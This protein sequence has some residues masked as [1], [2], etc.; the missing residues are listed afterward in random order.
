M[1][2][3]CVLVLLAILLAGIAVAEPLVVNLETDTVEALESARDAIEARLAEMQA[4]ESVSGMYREL[5]QNEQMYIGQELTVSGWILNIVEHLLYTEIELATAPD[6]AEVFYLTHRITAGRLGFAEG[7]FVKCIGNF[8]GM[9]EPKTGEGKP[10]PHLEAFSISHAEAIMSFGGGT[11]KAK[12]EQRADAPPTTEDFTVSGS[13][14]Y[15][16]THNVALVIRNNT[17]DTV[18]LS[19][20]VVFYDADD[21]MIGVANDYANTV[22]PGQEIALVMA[23]DEEFASY[24]YE[25]SATQD[26]WFAGAVS[27]L[28]TEVTQ[29]PSKVIV[30][31]KNISGETA[32]GVTGVILYLHEGH[33]VDYSYG[34]FGDADG[35]IKPGRRELWEFEADAKYD[36]VRVYMQGWK[37]L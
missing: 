29:L 10:L 1:K 11:E 4:G 34:F 9:A 30:A 6:G 3:V 32:Y 33:V 14:W 22:E 26:E 16:Y 15:D 2:R 31:V 28:E 35:E 20:R 25:I 17:V 37:E 12:T 5:M 36:D 19:V 23:N 24:E 18:N 21:K 8:A 7:D 13:T 27:L